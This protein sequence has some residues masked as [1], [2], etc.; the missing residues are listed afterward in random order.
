[1]FL[2]SFSFSFLASKEFILQ[3]AL[4]TLQSA[5]HHQVQ[6]VQRWSARQNSDLTLVSFFLCVKRLKISS[7]WLEVETEQSRDTW[8]L[9]VWC[10]DLY[11]T[12]SSSFITAIF[13]SN[14]SYSGVFLLKETEFFSFLFVLK[15]KG[16]IGR[17]Q[18][19]VPVYSICT[20]IVTFWS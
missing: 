4:L 5:S 13:N 7:K 2:V 20:E 8:V 1:M 17:L 6:R 9:P 11:F 10:I 18:N 12:I 15:W 16:C 19:E 3:I 14:S